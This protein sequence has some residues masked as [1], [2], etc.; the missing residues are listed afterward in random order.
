MPLHS[1]VTLTIFRLFSIFLLNTKRPRKWFSFE[2]YS[3]ILDYLFE[4][5]T[6][7]TWSIFGGMTTSKG[8]T[9]PTQ[10]KVFGMKIIRFVLNLIMRI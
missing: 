8:G 1:S 9:M 3:N 10:I 5:L 4:F 6:E 7:I 2:F